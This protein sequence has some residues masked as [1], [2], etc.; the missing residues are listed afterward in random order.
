MVAVV[1]EACV[2]DVGGGVG[3]EPRAA[4]VGSGPHGSEEH[5]DVVVAS[6]GGGDGVGGADGGG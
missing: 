3:G 5:P 6:A 2:T 1:V 4:L